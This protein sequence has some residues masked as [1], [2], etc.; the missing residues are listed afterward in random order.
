M[1]ILGN[2][3]LLPF[4]ADVLK[5]C[6]C[7]VDCFE[8]FEKLH[9]NIDICNLVGWNSNREEYIRRLLE[10]SFSGQAIQYF[11]QELDNYIDYFLNSFSVENPNIFDALDEFTRKMITRSNNKYCFRYEH[12]D[13]WRDFSRNI[14][15]EIILINAA[16][17]DHIIRH[18]KAPILDFSY[19]INCDSEEIR[20]ML[21]RDI[22][23]SENHFHL[24]GSSPYFYISWI[25]LMNHVDQPVYDYRIKAIERESLLRSGSGTNPVSLSILWKKAAAIRLYLYCQIESEYFSIRLGKNTYKIEC[26]SSFDKAF[27]ALMKKLKKLIFS[28]NIYDFDKFDLSQMIENCFG[29]T[30]LGWSGLQFSKSGDF[31][32]EIIYIDYAQLHPNIRRYAEKKYFNLIGERN[33]LCEVLRLIRSERVN[34]K[35]TSG[36]LYLY[37]TIKHRF[38][39][40]LVQSNNRVG[41]YNFQEYQ[42]RK[43]FFIPWS[44]SVEKAIA[45]NTISSIIDD[46]HIH[47]VELRISPE[48][49]VS[50]MLKIIR[51]YE[52]AIRDAIT[53]DNN[54][55]KSVSINDFFYTLHFMKFPDTKNEDCVFRNYK[56]RMKAK[57]Q[58][59]AIMKFCQ[60]SPRSELVVKKYM[61]S[62]KEYR[63]ENREYNYILSNKIL[64]IDACGEEMDCRPEVF[65]VTFR[66]LQHY[67]PL[68]MAHQLRATYHV[69]EDN[70]DIIDALRAIYEAVIFLDLRSGS[71]LGHATLLGISADEYYKR[72]R[73]MISMPIQNWLDN[74]VWLY[75]FIKENNISFDGCALL[76]DYLSNEFLQCFYQIYVPETTDSFVM[77]KF[78]EHNVDNPCFDI[79]HYFLSWLLRGDDPDI[80]INGFIDNS[81]IANPPYL[82]STSIEQMKEARNSPEACYLYYLY[83][84]RKSIKDKGMKNTVKKIP[85]Y[86]I[87]GAICAQKKLS[88]LIASLGIGIETNPTSNLFI[89]IINKYSEHPLSSFYSNGLDD[90][91]HNIQLN[92]SINTDDK[93]I[94]STSLSNEYTY[95]LFYLEQVKS[96]DGS[97]RYSRFEIL[98]WLNEIRQMGNEQSFAIK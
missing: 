84:Y 2:N 26:E 35:F 76:L 85:E 5:A 73:G 72:K 58:T 66:Y 39:Q 32:N 23:T 36:L 19:C 92:I 16:F 28:D 24:R 46:I 51:T 48:N 87:T 13:I 82:Y 95:L 4:L 11:R 21:K 3:M 53:L 68:E 78:S 10:D 12:T 81:V 69:A 64:G 27:D 75:Y 97:Q 25:Y 1:N 29:C 55:K 96:E 74:V 77:R 18:T 57:R 9:Q 43:D 49:S 22:G 93:S 60:M 45:T 37:L 50:E 94:F 15:E 30:S 88:E 33:L 47:K 83:H 34:N 42:N 61:Y 54:K 59:E 91:A 6:F 80:Y 40:E 52:S 8:L 17:N 7:N 63:I 62:D 71:R 44:Y 31:E 90:T 89:S 79:K 86:F 14:D 56:A 20:T 38:H 41:F 70:Y 65:G 98:K 67:C